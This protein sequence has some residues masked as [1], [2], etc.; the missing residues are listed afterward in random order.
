MAK[1]FLDYA[2]LEHYDGKIKAWANTN[3]AKTSFNNVAF[4]TETYTPSTLNDT[5]K[6]AGSAVSGLTKE[7]G[8]VTVNLTDEKTTLAGHYTP[9]NGTDVAIAGSVE[10]DSLAVVTGIS[11][12]SKGHV[13]SVQLN[14]VNIEFATK[15]EIDAFWS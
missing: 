12:D 15:A 9:A 8:S 2:G 11:Y 3:F 14:N 4:G 6:F 5:I 7:T 10:L 1:Q 13:T